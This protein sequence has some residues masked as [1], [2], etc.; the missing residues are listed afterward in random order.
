[1][2]G[3]RLAQALEAARSSRAYANYVEVR[4][5][6]L[7]VLD[8]HPG[9]GEAASEYWREEL[10][11]FDHLFDASPLV[12]TKL[13]EHCYHLTGLRSYDYRRHHRHKA[14]AFA[15][16][17]ASLREI[18]RADLFVPESPLLGGFGHEIDGALVNIDTLK[19][20][21]CLIALDRAGVLG[22][23]REGQGRGKILVEI[24]AGWGGFAYSVRTLCPGIR[25]VVVDLP[26]TLLF[27]GTYLK[28]VFPSSSVYLA[29][30]P[31]DIAKVEET[32]HDFLLI[33][34]L[35][36]AESRLPPP[37]V[38]VNIA[39]FQEMTT[40]Q[41]RA[42]AVKAHGL[43]GP[44]LYSLNRECS[45]HNT[46]LTA[47]S[48]AI[49][50]PYVIEQIPMLEASYTTLGRVPPAEHATGALGLAVR[51]YR[52]LLGR[53]SEGWWDKCTSSGC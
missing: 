18:D 20:Y 35:F 1:M 43:G 17:L 51:D 50:G 23:L 28:T 4:E 14:P 10:A 30:E 41:V 39:S 42:Y 2:T 21:E 40:E 22:P 45:P 46:D 29:R 25:Y 24:G 11:G 12:V 6:V 32:G 5:F 19:F 31:V 27:S 34:H 52:H 9:S 47:V 38:T 33:P 13:R 7:D 8:R 49:S 37:D 26:Q 48:E 53:R 3:S 36:F 16:K 15:A 44:V